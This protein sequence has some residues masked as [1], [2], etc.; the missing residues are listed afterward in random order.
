MIPY[1][2]QSINEED[3]AAVADVLRS[4]WLTQGAKVDAFERALADY[5]GAGYAVVFSS[6]TAAL[7]AAYFALG[8]ER[9]MEFITTPLTFAATANAGIWQGAK[10]IFVDIDP[11][12]GNLDPSKI[13]AAITP[14]TKAIVPV[15]Y[16]GH[17]A[18]LAAIRALADKHHLVILEDAC[19]ALGARFQGKHVGNFADATVYSFHP[20]KPITTGE[21][22]AVMTQSEDVARRL[23]LFRSH[24]IT[25][26]VFRHSSPGDWYYEMQELGQNYRL[27]DFQCALGLS[28]LKRLDAFLEARQRVAER[29]RVAFADVPQ[30]IIP[31]ERDGAKSGWHLYPIRLAGSCAGR[32]GEIFR[33]LRAAGIGVQVHYIPVY[34]H[35]YYREQGYQ[36]G[37]CPQA[38]AFYEAEISL[39]ISVGLTEADQAY[40]ISTVKTLLQKKRVLA[41][42]PARGGSKGIPRKNIRPFAGK[43][44]IAH[45]IETVRGVAELDRVIVSTEDEEIAT[46]A[47]AFGAE[48]PFMRPLELAGDVVP[49]LPVLV[50]VLQELERREGYVP[51]YVLLVY[52]T[53]PLLSASRIREAIELAVG[54]QAESV[55]SGR[56]DRKHFWIEAEDGWR[57]LYPTELENRQWSKPLFMENGAIYLTRSDVLKKNKI[58][59]ERIQVLAMEEHETID[60][61]TI[62]DFEN[63]EQLFLKGAHT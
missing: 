30:L 18:D 54:T 43:P 58:V 13:E 12:T 23:K 52:P 48:V 19:H 35:P 17:P 56:W 14:R 31:C 22:G 24:G 39:P 50:H 4:D 25:K 47:R 7:Q 38:E 41:I 42:I 49:T 45:I 34:W 29:Y 46:V 61:D 10:P 37:S 21:G 57:R 63:A 51:D 36:L 1:G 28:Q 2:H 27:T 53:S 62:E 8:I 20:V 55:V 60:I 5:T 44:L 59:G 32:R 6:G 26:E 15:D 40:V 9:G 33:K 16:A 3:I 11:V